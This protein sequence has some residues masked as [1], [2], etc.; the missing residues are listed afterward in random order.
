MRSSISIDNT[1]THRQLTLFKFMKQKSALHNLLFT[2]DCKWHFFKGIILMISYQMIWQVISEGNSME[3][4]FECH[5]ILW[6]AG[7]HGFTGVS[8]SSLSTRWQ[9]YSAVFVGFFFWLNFLPNEIC[10]FNIRT[11]KKG[12]RVSRGASN[13]CMLTYKAHV[14]VS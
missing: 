12:G 5:H 14:N 1:H 8:G 7:N 3:L 2:I 4:S 11:R 9:H 6:I 13:I 10:F